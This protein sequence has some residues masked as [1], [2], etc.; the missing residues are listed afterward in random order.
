M[1]NVFRVNF[2]SVILHQPK[3]S[4]ISFQRKISG[5]KFSSRSQNVVVIGKSKEINISK[6]HEVTHAIT[7]LSFS[8]KISVI[9]E[10]DT[11]TFLIIILL[12]SQPQRQC[13]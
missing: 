7:C 4:E 9:T 1:T 5:G 10:N 13:F 2:A 6:L 11:N 8:I 12:F 3:A